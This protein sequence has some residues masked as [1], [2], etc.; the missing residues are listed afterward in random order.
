[1]RIAMPRHA[2][3]RHAPPDATQMLL[4]WQRNARTALQWLHG[5]W[6]AYAFGVERNADVEP[7]LD[8]LRARCDEACSLAVSRVLLPTPPTLEAFIDVPAIRLDALPVDTGLRVLRMLALLTRRAEVRRLVDRG[9]R[10]RLADWIG[11]PLDALLGATVA[12]APS[13]IDAKRER[14]GTCALGSLDA[15]A[16][17][18]E[19]LALLARHHTQVMLL[20]LALPRNECPHQPQPSEDECNEALALLR[21]RIGPLLPEYAWLSG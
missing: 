2:D 9:T 21:E 17:A 8:T 20:P 7:A 1:M 15:D 18:H 14:A 3:A 11:C 4:G 12:E 16:L 5:D 6:L 10:R 13:L 19:G